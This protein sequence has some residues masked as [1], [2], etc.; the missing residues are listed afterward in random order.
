MSVSHKLKPCYPKS[1]YSSINDQFFHRKL[2]SQMPIYYIHVKTWQDYRTPLK[3]WFQISQISLTPPFI[4]LNS[5][6]N[7][8]KDSMY[9]KLY[10][11]SQKQNF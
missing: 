8:L 5:L 2:K 4:T 1:F 11:S 7:A 9:F 3:M 10:N 6:K